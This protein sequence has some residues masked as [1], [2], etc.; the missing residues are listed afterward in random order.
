MLVSA[1]IF[2]IILFGIVGVFVA[3]NRG[4]AG[5][6]GF[7]LG[8]FLGPL[9]VIIV[10]LLKEGTGIISSGA[11]YCGERDVFSDQYR[12]W[13][14]NKYGIQRNL[15]LDRFVINSQVF[16][17]L[18]DALAFANNLELV[19]IEKSQ[20]SASEWVETLRLILKIGIIFAGIIVVFVAGREL[21]GFIQSQREKREQQEAVSRA[22][23]AI[24]SMKHQVSKALGEIGVSLPKNST[25]TAINYNDLEPEELDSKIFI[26][27]SVGGG[28]VTG[29]DQCSFINSDGKESY[30]GGKL[31][32][33]FVEGDP[34]SI[35]KFYDREFS[36][37]R[38]IKSSE[39]FE[40]ETV[41]SVY[42]GPEKI[43]ILN[44]VEQGIYPTRV[45][46]CVFQ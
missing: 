11:V 1:V 46:I 34:I 2:S 25:M 17:N 3:K 41:R 43:V 27:A 38:F 24:M 44:A 6:I 29:H 13:L 23:D 32:R 20:T 10:A 21:L 37:A 16:E 9:G 8:I 45:D 31:I 39:K 4:V 7:F 33:F 26:G 40:I 35:E 30:S 28:D 19:Q 36:G 14:I 5:R 15:V 18:D 42:R 22:N 12:L